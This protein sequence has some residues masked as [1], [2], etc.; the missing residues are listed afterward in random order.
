MFVPV[1]NGQYVAEEEAAVW[2]LPATA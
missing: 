2:F 1:D